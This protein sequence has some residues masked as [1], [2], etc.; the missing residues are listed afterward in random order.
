MGD[1]S[2]TC[3]GSS[4]QILPL[5]GWS[6]PLSPVAARPSVLSL[7]TPWHLLASGGAVAQPRQPGPVY[8][9]QSLRLL[10]GGACLPKLALYPVNVCER[11]AYLVAQGGVP[12]QEVRPLRPHPLEHRAQHL[13]VAR[14]P[15]SG[16]AQKPHPVLLPPPA[17]AVNMPQLRLVPRHQHGDR[18]LALLGVPNQL[19]DVNLGNRRL[20]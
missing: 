6:A 18:K 17:L 7:T 11:P 15:G 5:T 3:R 1:E 12:L 14:E 20:V 16:R 2:L 10:D 9:G 4:C 8:C 19:P 13:Q